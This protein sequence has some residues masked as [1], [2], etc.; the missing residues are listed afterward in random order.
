MLPEKSFYN[1]V[2]SVLMVVTCIGSFPL[3]LSPTHE[4]I[5]GSWG[6]PKT[7]RYF[8]TS[9]RFVLFRVIETILVSVVAKLLPSFSAILGFNILWR[10]VRG[11]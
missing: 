7:N 3:Y 10:E 8:I 11:S 1:V 2:V 9:P 6:E 5:E 4:V